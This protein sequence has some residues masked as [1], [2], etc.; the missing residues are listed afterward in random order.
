MYL[1]RGT[2]ISL[3]A[4]FVAYAFLS[5]ILVFVWR[6]LGRVHSIQSADILYGIRVLPLIAASGLVVFF[7]VP[8][9][10]YLEPY[11]TD[12]RIG[13]GALAMAAAGATVIFSGLLNSA[14]AWLTTSRFMTACLARSRRLETA[15]GICAYEMLDED[16]VLFVAGVWRSKLLVSSGAVA[17]L[18]AGE[19]QAA[20]QHEVAH[21]NRGDNLKKLVLRLCALPW[22]DSLE[23]EWVRATEMAADGA[24]AHDEE[25]ALNL[26]SALIKMTQVSSRTRTP[27]L[28]MTLLPPNGASVTA[29][30]ERLLSGSASTDRN[31]RVVW[32]VLLAATV[33]AV[34]VPYA[35]ALAQMHG[36]TELLLR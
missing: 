17:L 24:A 12:E 6:T 27:E 1:L 23:R 5:V 36:V 18:D 33:L 8:S 7:T 21:A 9:F 13:A 20:I 29:R 10:L 25:T 19:I 11:L 28:G 14:K 22:F 3:A 26:A 15:E 16:P 4:F 34:S 35:R 32:W 30:V 2:V 31:S